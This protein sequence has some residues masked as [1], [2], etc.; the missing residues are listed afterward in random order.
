MINTTNYYT[1]WTNVFEFKNKN[2][3]KKSTKKKNDNTTQIHNRSIRV[4]FM[5]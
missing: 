3:K 5:L 4:D 1:Y 2:V